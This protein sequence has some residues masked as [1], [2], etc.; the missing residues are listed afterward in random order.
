MIKRLYAAFSNNIS[1]IKYA[2]SELRADRKFILNAISIDSY[3]FNIA[4]SEPQNDKE[5]VLKAVSNCN[6]IDHH[7]QHLVTSYELRNDKEIVTTAIKK[8]YYAFDCISN[9]LKKDK[10]FVRFLISNSDLTLDY[11][12]SHFKDVAWNSLGSLFKH[13]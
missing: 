8:N 4:S 13:F 11:V 6:S 1:S 7:L 10:E 9:E 3:P 2:S 12:N 5:I